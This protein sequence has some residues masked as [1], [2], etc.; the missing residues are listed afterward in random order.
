[1]GGPTPEI[2]RASIRRD[3]ALIADLI[4]DGARVLDVGCGDGALLDFLTKHKQVDGRGLEI[5]HANVATCA[6]KGLSV[7]QGDA[8]E[9]LEDYADDVFDFVVLSDTLQATEDP[10]AVLNELTR[11]GRR[12]VISFLN[13]GHWTMFMKRLWNGR[14]PRTADFPE[15]WWETPAIRP[16][17]ILDFHDLIAALDLRV[18]HAAT[19]DR[20]GAARRLERTLLPSIRARRATFVVAR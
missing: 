20:R 18:E 7:I 11:I 19:I 4:G 10:V 17:T 5:D 13:Y 9:D 2:A 16:C 12:V 1:M 15:P 6:A 14:T 3:L 8:E